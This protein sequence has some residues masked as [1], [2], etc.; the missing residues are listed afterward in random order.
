[1]ARKR[2][3]TIEEVA[4][5]IA[6][7]AVRHLSQFSEKEQ[8]RRILAAEKRLAISSRAASPRTCPSSKS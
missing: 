4:E 7:I 6:K 5:E 1:M 3:R 2:K 8:E